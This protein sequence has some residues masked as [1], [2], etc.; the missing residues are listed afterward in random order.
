MY[1]SLINFF[2]SVLILTAGLG[3]LWGLLKFLLFK[4]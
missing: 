2:F 1:V 3:I 4:I